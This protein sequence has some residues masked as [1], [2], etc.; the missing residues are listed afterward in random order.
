MYIGELVHGIAEVLIAD[1]GLIRPIAVLML[2]QDQPDAKVLRYGKRSAE[3]RIGIVETFNTLTH[4]RLVGGQRV[5]EEYPLSVQT[6][7]GE[8]RKGL[9]HI[10]SMLSW[11]YCA[12]RRCGVLITLR[13]AHTTPPLE[14]RWTAGCSRRMYRHSKN[15]GRERDE[16]QQ[17]FPR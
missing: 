12:G 11:K 10:G 14:K 8:V 6:F 13:N 5:I 2:I 17:V 1:G 16:N 15:Q 3:S 4:H 9:F 7:P